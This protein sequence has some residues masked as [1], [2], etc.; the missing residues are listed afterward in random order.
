MRKAILNNFY[1]IKIIFRY[2]PFYVF[3]VI[4]LSVA[5]SINTVISILYMRYMINIMI[6]GLIYTIS[7]ILQCQMMILS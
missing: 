2:C 1:M 3:F 6:I 7:C 5:G 4:L